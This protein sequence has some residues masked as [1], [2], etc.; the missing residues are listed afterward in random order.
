MADLLSMYLRTL[1]ACDPRRLIQ[2][3]APA[4]S[5][6]N[7]VAIGK[8]AGSLLDGYPHAISESLAIVP[9]G[10]PRPS[11]GRVVYGG[12]PAMTGESFE[13]GAI[14]LRF[15]EEHDDIAFLISGGGSAVV[16]GPLERWLTRDDVRIVNDR[17]VVSGL[18]ISDINIVRKHISAI[19]GG[20][21]AQRVRGTLV[22]LIYSDVGTGALAD[23]AS[24]PTL[25]DPSTKAQA[26]RILARIG[27]CD[28][29]VTRLNDPDF[30]ETEKDAGGST[31]LIADNNTLTLT[32][33]RLCREDG[34]VAELWE[35]Q[36]ESPVEE[37]AAALAERASALADGEVLIAGGEPTV[38]VR[39]DGMGGRCSELAVRFALEAADRDLNVEAVFA[40]SDGVDGNSGTAGIHLAGKPVIRDRARVEAALARSDSMSVAREIGAPIVMPATGNNLRDLFLMRLHP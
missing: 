22:S 14:L 31:F 10:Y 11:R 28:H 19:K 21:L 12:H 18:P 24:G 9:R 26:A 33:A 25:P 27:E 4:G 16:E 20:R 1:E 5:P 37:A 7:V 35:G 36:I 2:S 15:V 34:L 38:T 8:C 3:A 17:L 29:I 32:A 39:G 6:R 40:S 13:A 23:V 30:P